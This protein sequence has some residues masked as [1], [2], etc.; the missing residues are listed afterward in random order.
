MSKLLDMLG[1]GK[2][3]IA[4]AVAPLIEGE[5]RRMPEAAAPAGMDDPL[6][7]APSAL[8]IPEPAPVEASLLTRIRTMSLR[9]PA[10]SPFLPCRRFPPPPS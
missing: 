3:E 10:P 9:V 8:A 1:K 7:P 5:I 2:G 6:S 4:E